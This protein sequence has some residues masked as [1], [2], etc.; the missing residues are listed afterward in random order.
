MAWGKSEEEKQQEREAKEQ[1]ARAQQE[2]YEQQ[3]RAEAD[4]AFASSPV[5]RAQAAHQ[6][7]DAF[8]QLEVEVSALTGPTSFFGS[9]SNEIQHSAV[10]TDLLGQVEAAG[11]HLEHVGYVFIETGSTTTDRVLLSGQGM[12]TQGNVTG[13]YLFRRAAA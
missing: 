7:N 9:S 3:Q 13:I 5:G 1:Q 10:A 8:F 6:R 2:A 4:A 12:V 11:W